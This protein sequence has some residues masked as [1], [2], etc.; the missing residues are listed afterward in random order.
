MIRFA[1][2]TFA[3]QVSWL[4]LAA[5]AQPQN[6]CAECL[7]V[8]IGPPKIVRGPSGQE[9]DAPFVVI[10]RGNGEFRGF[11]S[12][13]RTYAI[14]GASPLDMGGNKRVVLQ[15]GRKGTLSDCGN[16]LTGALPLDGKLFGLIHGESGCDYD[17]NQ[18]HKAMAVATSIDEGLNWTILGAAITGADKAAP[19]KQTGE[20]DCT[21]ADG[22]DTFLYIYCLRASDWKI[23]AARAPRANPAPGQWMKWDGI[24]WRIPAL[25]RAGAPLPGFPGHSA[26]YFA[27]R[28]TMLLLAV[29]KSLKLSLS[30]DKVNFTQVPAPLV[31]YETDEWRR[32]A[33]DA[34]YAY[35]SLVGENG[36]NTIGERGFLT[37]AYVPPKEDFTQRYLIMHEITLTPHANA[38]T[39]HVR[40]ALSRHKAADG[41]LWTTVAP[42]I[43]KGPRTFTHE[44]TLGDLMTA[45][46]KEPSDKIEEC[47]RESVGTIDYRLAAGTCDSGFR[48]QRTAGFIYR[49]AQAGT[50]ALYACTAP[51]GRFRF[52]STEENCEGLGTNEKR[53][54]YVLK[55]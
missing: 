47:V 10:K 33:P 42:A 2:A 31:I 15:P 11:T 44:K 40:T 54:G 16:W 25:D 4:A 7:A 14:D 45:A 12:N 34:L 29:D 13:H 43:E 8:R 17:K 49:E 18:T 46:P 24:G 26:A 37:Y 3:L 20:G 1:V 23:T 6:L 36:T 28:N 22:G 5:Q 38:Q 51:G 19:A 30:A 52:A 39:P 9:S 50:S 32:P 48:R 27:P 53:L 35:P 55:P 21:L 41:R